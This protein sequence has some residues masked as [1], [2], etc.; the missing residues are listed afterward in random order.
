MKCEDHSCVW[1]APCNG[2]KD[3]K[4]GS[5]EVG[6]QGYIAII[7]LHV[8]EPIGLTVLI[9]KLAYV[10]YIYISCQKFS[11]LCL[12]CKYIKY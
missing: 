1:G 7:Q 11:L 8:T 10:C 4:D 12:D 2:K 3:C 9:V 5:D 6:C